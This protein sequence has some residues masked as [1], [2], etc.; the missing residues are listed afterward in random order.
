DRQEEKNRWIKEESSFDYDRN[1]KIKNNDKEIHFTKEYLNEKLNES[2]KDSFAQTSD[3]NVLFHIESSKMIHIQN[4]F[5]KYEFDEL[6]TPLNDRIENELIPV[7]VEKGIK[8]LTKESL[9][10]EEKTAE[11]LQKEAVFERILDKEKINELFNEKDKFNLESKN[12][13]ID[14]IKL[15]LNN[16]EFSHKDNI[17]SL[18]EEKIPDDKR[19]SSEKIQSLIEELSD[20]V[21]NTEL[22]KSEK[23]ILLTELIVGV[24]KASGLNKGQRNAIEETLLSEDKNL[25]WEGVA[26]AGKTY[27][28][29]TVIDEAKKVGYD[30]RGFA[31]NGDAASILSTET[32][33]QAQTIDSLVLSKQND[34]SFQ[35]NKKLWI[36]DES[37]LIN[38]KLGY[39]LVKRADAENARMIIVGGI[40]QLSAPSSGHFLKFVSRYTNIKTVRLDESVRQKNRDLAQGVKYLNAFDL[41]KLDSIYYKNTA[42]ELAQKAVF[43][44]KS[45]IEEYK[46]EE[47][48]VQNAVKYF[49]S[50]NE[51]EMNKSLIVAKT[52]SAIYEITNGIRKGLKDRGYLKNEIEAN[53]YIPVSVSKNQLKYAL[54]YEIG[55][56]VVT[57]NPKTS[58]KANESY[59]I[60]DRDTINNTITV[61]D[62]NGYKIVVKPGDVKDIFQFK[63]QKINIAEND[64]MSWRKNSKERG[65][66]NKQMFKIMEID[67]VSNTAK[68]KYEKG[69]EDT[70]YLDKLNFMSHSWA[71][72]YNASQGATKKNTIGLIES[73]CGHEEIYTVFT[74]STHTLKIFAESK[75]AIEKSLLKS[76][77]NLT[78]TEIMIE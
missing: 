56:V 5:G 32:G 42:K 67:K 39:E 4:N 44:F 13:I 64:W 69:T 14:D 57:E 62:P 3:R 21:S 43:H 47:G 58:L 11:I 75:E 35:N 72:T 28:L 33:I 15:S 30:V 48:R 7:Q 41:Q 1:L 36:I 18:V 51:S 17:I 63:A 74:R 19:L 23:N 26:G 52:H 40:S 49:L 38:A 10:I 34:T 66:L 53:S 24:T 73:Y 22:N 59:L 50:L 31:Q 54:N 25:I 27:S 9:E 71:V 68:I 76:K 12:R 55:N 8:Y 78:A 6:M 16:Y 29:K 37:G 46:T 61:S 65:R 45:S 20:L 70:I 2:V 60:T 77:S